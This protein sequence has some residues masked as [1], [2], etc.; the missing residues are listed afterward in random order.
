[1]D[2][3]PDHESV[4]DNTEGAPLMATYRL[5][6]S[7][8]V[9][10]PGLVAWAINGYAFKAD[11]KKLLAVMQAWQGVPDDALKALLSKEVPFTVEDEAVVFSYGEPDGPVSAS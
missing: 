7:G 9:S 5:G 4:L 1:M 8:F 10:A 3:R 6:S 2:A 11:R